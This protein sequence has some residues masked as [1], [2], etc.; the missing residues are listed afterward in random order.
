[1]TDFPRKSTRLIFGLLE[2]FG[3]S[4]R[5][6]Q[7]T[8]IGPSPNVFFSDVADLLDLC[9]N[10]RSLRIRAGTS[11][12]NPSGIREFMTFH[13]STCVSPTL[14]ETACVALRHHLQREQSTIELLSLPTTLF[15][16]PFIC[17][18]GVSRALKVLQ[19][20]DDMVFV[21]GQYD[22][23]VEIAARRL[24]GQELPVLESLELSFAFHQNMPWPR[25]VVH[26]LFRVLGVM[27]F[28]A[29]RHLLVGSALAFPEVRDLVACCSETL[30]TFHY[31][32]S[33]TNL[34]KFT[35]PALPR[36]RELLL[37]ALGASYILPKTVCPELQRVFID[38]GEII[39]DSWV[40]DNLIKPALVN[41]VRNVAPP[42]LKTAYLFGLSPPDE[43]RE[44]IEEMCKEMDI[45]YQFGDV[46]VV[47]EHEQYPWSAEIIRLMW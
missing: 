40:A 43:G 17:A 4:V 2:T 47:P 7:L 10:L 12:S 25:G 46:R 38:T 32:Y 13:N 22:E 23:D 42:R 34:L 18:L 30:E 6:L 14:M 5:E 16:A 1:M 33:G 45:C 37:P 31:A 41:I 19:L 27:H 20:H 35:L 9:P 3:T 39:A 36:V 15:M 21:I 11:C 28:P 24:R 44:S 8:A 26:P 29:L